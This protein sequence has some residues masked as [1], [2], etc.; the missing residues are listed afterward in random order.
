MIVITKGS[1]ERHFVIHG[2]LI[3]KWYLSTVASVL[4]ANVTNRVM[5]WFVSSLLIFQAVLFL[6]LLIL[7][8]ENKN[9]KVCFEGNL[10][11]Q[12]RLT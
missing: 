8:G 2:F 9:N 6:N 5:N 1:G 10:D 7:K 11:L 3:G 12:F 4:R